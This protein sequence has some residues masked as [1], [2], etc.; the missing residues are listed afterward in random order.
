M[1][2]G[3]PCFPPGSSC[4][5]VLWILLAVFC[6]RLRGFYPLWLD[7]PVNSTSIPQCVTQSSTPTVLL[8]SVCPLSISLAATLKI[9]FD[10][11]S[12]AYLD[13]SVQRVS[14]HI[15]IYSVYDNRVLLCWVSPFGNLRIYGYLHLPVA[16]RSLSRPS[17]APNAKAFSMCS[18]SLDL[19]ANLYAASFPA[20]AG[21]L[22]CFEFAPLP[23][24]ACVFGSPEC[25]T[26][27]F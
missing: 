20:S 7:F 2:S 27:C 5:A 24:N 15:P 26:L 13:V 10:F 22:L 8:P 11:S 6:F 12:S 17:S 23:K 21:K 1:D 25:L 9:S 18:S 19:V 14:P 4:P 3:L 16:Y